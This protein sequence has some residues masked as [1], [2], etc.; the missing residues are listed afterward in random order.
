MNER[1]TVVY[2]DGCPT[3]TVGKNLSEKLDKNKKLDFVGM[4]TERGHSLVHEHGLDMHASAYAIR[5]GKVSGKSAMVRDVL[6]HNGTLGFFISLPFRIPWVGDRLYELIARHR[7][8][9]FRE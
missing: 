7:S 9:D 8:H 1:L 3:C 2:D 5:D 6:T 4:N